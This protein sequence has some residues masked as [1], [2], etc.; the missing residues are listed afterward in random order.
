MTRTKGAE[1]HVFCSGWVGRE[2]GKNTSI[3]NFKIEFSMVVIER[4][5]VNTFSILLHTCIQM[6]GPEQRNQEIALL[7][8]TATNW[9]K[10]QWSGYF[11]VVIQIQKLCTSESTQRYNF[12]LLLPLPRRFGRKWHHWCARPLMRFSFPASLCQRIHRS[13][14]LL[15]VCLTRRLHK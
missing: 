12:R 3:T 2:F 1:V 4:T 10:H 9:V 14:V 8:F 13:Q 5:T 11:D 6:V 7:W 15:K